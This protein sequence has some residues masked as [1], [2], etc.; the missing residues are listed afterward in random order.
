MTSHEITKRHTTYR[1]P[2][3][4]RCNNDTTIHKTYHESKDGPN[5]SWDIFVR[6]DNVQHTGQWHGSIARVMEFRRRHIW[7]VLLLLQLRWRR[8]VMVT[9][10]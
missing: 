2:Q 1:Q 8:R 9:A 3:S 7:F 6:L 4:Q 10:A 5:S